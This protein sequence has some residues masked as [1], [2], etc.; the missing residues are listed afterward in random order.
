M[1]MLP[2]TTSRRVARSAPRPHDSCVTSLSCVAKKFDFVSL[3]RPGIVD[4]ARARLEMQAAAS[5]AN[6]SSFLIGEL[7]LG[8]L[9]ET[10]V[11]VGNAPHDRPGFFV[12]H[13]IGNR[14]SFLCTKAPMLRIPNELS[15]W[16]SQDLLKAKPSLGRHGSMQIGPGLGANGFSNLVEAPGGNTARP[17]ERASRV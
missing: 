5:I 11:V 7:L 15:G 9:S 10:V 14:A 17:G 12:G 2:S 8:K 1:F 3:A 13:L 16:H 4:E 6:R